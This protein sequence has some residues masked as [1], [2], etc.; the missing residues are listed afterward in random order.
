MTDSW[1]ILKE[2]LQLLEVMLDGHNFQTVLRRTSCLI[3]HEMLKNLQLYTGSWVG[4]LYDNRLKIT[5]LKIYF[6]SRSH[7][8]FP[9][10]T[11]VRMKFISN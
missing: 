2:P 3:E 11:V 10:G 1:S 4:L 8:T 5:V 7:K 6:F 9:V